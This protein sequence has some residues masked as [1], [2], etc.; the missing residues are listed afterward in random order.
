MGREAVVFQIAVT[1]MN[2]YTENDQRDIY[3]CYGQKPER[4]LELWQIHLEITG[5]GMPLRK[6]D[7]SGPLA[8]YQANFRYIGDDSKRT[9]S[10]GSCKGF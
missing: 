4:S 5:W 3:D 7:S 1:Q 10:A 9:T 6:N 8:V 2:T